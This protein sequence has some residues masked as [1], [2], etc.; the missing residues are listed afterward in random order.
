MLRG[1]GIAVCPSLRL[2]NRLKWPYN[3]QS[4]V[5]TFENLGILYNIIYICFNGDAGWAIININDWKVEKESM[6][7]PIRSHFS[8]YKSSVLYQMNWVAV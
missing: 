8:Y 1:F 4:K 7:A 5:W 3:A 6:I 2:S